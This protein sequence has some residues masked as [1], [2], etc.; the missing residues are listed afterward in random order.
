MKNI[1]LFTSLLFTGTTN[2][3]LL[4]IGNFTDNGGGSYTL[5]T[6]SNIPD[7]TIENFVGLPAGQLDLL[8]TGNATV[9]S[10][11]TD[12]FNITAGQTFSFDWSW[13]SDEIQGA[14]F[15]DFS[16]YSLSLNGSGVLADT[17]TPDGT[18][19][20]FSWL[21]SSSGLLQYG[22]GVM[23]VNDQIV[24]SFLTV[25]NISL[26]SNNNN[27]P[28]PTS[29]ALLGLGLAGLSFSRKKKTA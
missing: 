5:S 27:V 29:I 4:S 9:G 16:F 26:S 10:A 20:S 13:T 17:F 11:I 28:E 19:S 6:N 21:A 14:T 25:N 2:A 12:S 3:A 15:N 1:I 22:I 24:D 23:D 7:T 8:S 18:T